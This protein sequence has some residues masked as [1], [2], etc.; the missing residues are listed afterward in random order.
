[1]TTCTSTEIV[2]TSSLGLSC[3]G[4]KGVEKKTSA[5]AAAAP[6]APRPPEAPPRPEKEFRDAIDLLLG[7]TA[8]GR[9]SFPAAVEPIVSAA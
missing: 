5:R 6:L 1:M 7:K 9:L 4:A 2:V 3:P 8:R